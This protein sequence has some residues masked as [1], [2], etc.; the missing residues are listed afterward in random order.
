MLYNRSLLLVIHF[1]YSSVYTSIPDSLTIRSPHP[2]DVL[3]YCF[4]ETAVLLPLNL[5]WDA[6][7]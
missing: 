4:T 5:G 7:L 6:V 2:C 3:L 1:K